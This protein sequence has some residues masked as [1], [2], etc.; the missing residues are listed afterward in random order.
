MSQ[1][2]GGIWEVLCPCG[3]VTS[4]LNLLRGGKNEMS[5]HNRSRSP[6]LAAMSEESAGSVSPSSAAVTEDADALQQYFRDMAQFPLLD[7]A[8]MV[9]LAKLWEQG[10][11]GAKNTLVEGNLRLVV[12]IAKRY[13]NRGVPLLDL[14]QEGN[15]GLMRAVEKFDYRSG[16]R[17][18]TYATW[19]IRQAVARAVADH[20]RT[21]RLPVHMHEKVSRLHRVVYTLQQQHDTATPAMVAESLNVSVD[22]VIHMMQYD[23][24]ALS[25]DMPM[26]EE[27][28]T[29]LADFV[30][31]PQAV[32]P[33]DYATDQWLHSRL[34][35]AFKH[36]SSQQKRVL[37]LRFGWD[38]DGHARTLEETGQILGLSRERIR[39]I[40]QAAL[41]K[42]RN[43][44]DMDALREH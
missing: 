11:H 31:D 35:S 24:P 34:D 43:T 42:L 5:R 29:L 22:E 44:P 39:Q 6:S 21:I 40:E 17:F 19:W 30:A 9:A 4:T 16:Y 23:Q 13:V 15:A 37:H 1:S 36:L 18:S 20:G 38:D 26:Q 8:T 27:Q 25:L 12:S 41:C 10:D 3:M 7:H 32:P 2:V 33:E 28:D 14:I